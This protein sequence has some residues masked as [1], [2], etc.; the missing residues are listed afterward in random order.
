MSDPRISDEAVKKAVDAYWTASGNR[1][2]SM[3][4]ALEAA[5]PY[6]ETDQIHSRITVNALEDAADAILVPGASSKAAAWLRERAR[7][8]A[9]RAEES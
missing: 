2:V 3:R 6:L 5:L 9:L 8:L 7:L 4:A 1:A